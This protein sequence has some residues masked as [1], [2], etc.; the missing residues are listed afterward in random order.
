MVG[1]RW[2]PFW[3]TILLFATVDGSEIMRLPV[4]VG[5]FSHYLQDFVYIAGGCLGFLNHQQYDILLMEEILH[6]LGCNVSFRED[7]YRSMVNSFLDKGFCTAH[8]LLCSWKSYMKEIWK[9]IKICSNSEPRK[10]PSYFPLNPGWS[11]GNPYIGL[12]NNPCIT[13]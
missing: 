9:N 7:W 6:H 11:I 4:E 10:T 12:W 8:C 5:S 13:G 1:R 3:D 2:F